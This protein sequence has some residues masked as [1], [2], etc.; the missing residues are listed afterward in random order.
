M[1]IGELIYQGK[2]K[3]IYKSDNDDELIALFRDDMT[4]FNGEK[5]DQF[6]GKGVYNATVSAFFF[7][8]L[9]K[10]GIKTHFIRMID[11][12]TM[13]VSKLE[14]IPLEVIARN[15]AAGSITKKLPLKEGQVLN[16]PVIVTDYKDDAKGDPAV[17]DDLIL[18]LGLL[19]RDE[20]NEARRTTLEINK[21]LYDFFDELGLVLVDFKIE[22]GRRGNEII[23]G[24]EISMDSMR[25][26]DKE[27][28]ESFDKDVYRFNKGDV[29]T[30]YARVVEKIIN[31]K[32]E[33]IK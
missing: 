14:M 10:H 23:L 29:M 22:F 3:S 21:L 15:R 8:Y 27:T 5:H 2:A 18:A 19:T 12:K 6:S 16:P 20:L 7:D 25:L 11:E 13:L 1:E 4:A 30:A 24:D 17:N 9:E 33:Q 26:W 32:K 28:G 31:W